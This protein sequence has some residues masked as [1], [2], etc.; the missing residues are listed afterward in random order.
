MGDR[1]LDFKLLECLKVLV[2]ERH[3]TRAAER[4]RMSQPK[5]SSALARL[6]H[7][8]GDPL[9]VRTPEGM[10]PTP[11]ARELAAQSG[12]FLDRWR[13]LVGLDSQFEPAT[14]NQSFGIR[15]IDMIAQDLVVACAPRIR[16]TAPL[17]SIEISGGRDSGV[18][19][20]L[21]RGEVDMVLA[22]MPDLPADFFI[23]LLTVYD[24]CCIASVDHPRL[25]HE[26]DL[27]AYAAEAHVKMTRGFKHFPLIIE[28]RIDSLLAS[29]GLERNVAFYSHS[30]MLVPDIVARTDLIA[31]MPRH[32]AEEASTRLG[33]QLF[34]VPLPLRKQEVSLIWH[35]RTNND[36]G[37]R[38]LRSVLRSVAQRRATG[39]AAK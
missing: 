14:S 18:R 13:S 23:S 37:N 4:L 33:L 27:K 17:I 15:A 34:E 38:W 31:T 12:E 28:D 25:R 36:P 2:A 19:A 6:R 24:L 11:L 8:T 22:W 3:V 20:A 29:K 30:M 16:E 21:E 9:L 7:M 32:L 35:A 5:L 10:M 1:H 39:R 26:L